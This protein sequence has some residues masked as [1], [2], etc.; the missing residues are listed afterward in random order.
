MSEEFEVLSRQVA[1]A[2][3]GVYLAHSEYTHDDWG[4]EAEKIDA[5][6]KN[7]IMEALAADAA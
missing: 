4:N 2:C 3:A 7:A 6:Y 1:K 5:W